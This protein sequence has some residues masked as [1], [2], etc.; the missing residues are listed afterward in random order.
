MAKAIIEE[1]LSCPRDDFAIPKAGEFF[2]RESA[3]RR[4]SVLP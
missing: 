2:I 3:D 1:K 4:W